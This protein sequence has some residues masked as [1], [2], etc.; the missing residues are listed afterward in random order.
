MRLIA[1]ACAAALLTGCG[2]DRSESLPAA[3]TEGPDAVLKAL[4][5][6]PKPVTIDGTPISRCF[7]RDARGDDVQIVG[8]VLLAVAQELG[9]RARAGD[10]E[11]AL[12][13]GYL[14]GAAQ[15]GARRNGLAAELVRR[16]EVETTRLG[17][18]APEYRRG[19]RAGRA[20]G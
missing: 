15:R 14:I 16:L 1:I 17:A 8:S 10:R 9:D 20:Q 3:C 6:A 18:N 4:E 5:R 19:V 7:N 2:S 13:L 12:R 11:A